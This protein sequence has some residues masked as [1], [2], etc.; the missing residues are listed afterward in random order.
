MDMPQRNSIFVKFYSVLLDIND[1]YINYYSY[2]TYNLRK[3]F[4]CFIKNILFVYLFI[5]VI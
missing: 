2:L 5:Y 3:I 4:N 1:S